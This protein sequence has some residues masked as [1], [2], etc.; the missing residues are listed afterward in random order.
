VSIKVF[1]SAESTAMQA[2][3]HVR[4][5]AR[6][7]IAGRGRFLIALAGGTTPQTVYRNLARM[8]DIEWPRVEVFFGDERCVPPDDPASNYRM[9]REALLEHVPVRLGAV[10]RIA[11]EIDPVEAA[12]L[13][14][15]DLLVIAGLP[16]RLD[17]VLLGVG[18]DGHTASLFPDTPDLTANAHP[19]ALATRAPVEPKDRVSLSLD[20]ICGARNVTMLTVGK[21]KEEIVRRLLDTAEGRSLP[22]ALVRTRAGSFDWFMDRDAHPGTENE[23]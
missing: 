19:I 21:A 12:A 16:P 13:Y 23:P 14:S 2:A 1:R 4:E 11:G 7:A 20:T 10:H 18:N 6:R 22:A 5:H 9:A 8:T 15:E 17:M 3:I